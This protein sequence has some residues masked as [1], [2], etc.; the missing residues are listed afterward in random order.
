MCG[1]EPAGCAEIDSDDED[2]EGTCAETHF[3]GA[4]VRKE[5]LGADDSDDEEYEDDDWAFDV[6]DYGLRLS[7]P[8][9]GS[10]GAS[11]GAGHL[12]PAGS[13]ALRAQSNLSSAARTDIA[14]CEKKADAPR[15]L[16]LT[17]DTRATVEQV[18]D[19]RTMLVLGKMLKRGVYSQIFGT[20]STGKE[21]NV[22]YATGHKPSAVLGNMGEYLPEGVDVAVKVYKTSILVFKDRARYVEGEFRFRRGYCKSNP[23]KMVAMWAEKEMRNLRRMRNAHL[24]CPIPVEVRQNVLVMEYVGQDGAAAPRLKDAEVSQDAWPGLYRML[25]RI[26]RTIFQ[27]CKLVH[28]DLSEYN[29][30]HYR[31]ALYVIDVS[32]SVEHDHPQAL[33]FLKRDLVNVNDFFGRM[34][35]PVVPIRKL[36]DFILAEASRSAEAPVDPANAL[37]PT[38]EAQ[39]DELLQ[40]A[41]IADMY[42]VEQTNEEE[43]E[44]QVFLNT[45]TVSHL[46][47]VSDIAEIEKDM[48]QREF[49]EDNLY[50]RLVGDTSGT[51]G[52]LGSDT[53]ESGD[54]AVVDGDEPGASPQEKSDDDD[55]DP[56]GDGEPKFN[57]HKP[58]GMDKAAWKAQVK[59]E[60][61]EKRLTKMSKF[62]KKKRTKKKH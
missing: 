46:N 16:G 56:E 25:I 33:E 1:F 60:K 52:V 28:G 26:V 48:K 5:R 39:L 55:D 58:E 15:N 40:D 50:D 47:Q 43:I 4:K 30:L 9:A 38:E 49:G 13:V 34:S 2:F 22:Y 32:Q 6:D 21:A 35:V 37:S 10:Q 62:D 7:Q 8:L 3:A 53:D 23:R 41:K 11:L 44:E 51:R 29:I 12:Q 14:L 45:W 27:V 36:F 42:D 59:A 54:E 24:P 18:L 57:G 19:P 20:I 17:R 31:D 61:A